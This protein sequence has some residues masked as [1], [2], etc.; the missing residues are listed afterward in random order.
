[1]NYTQAASICIV[2]FLS[3][4]FVPCLWVFPVTGLTL[5]RGRAFV[6]ARAQLSLWRCVIWPFAGRLSSYGSTRESAEG[7]GRKNGD[8]P[9]EGKRIELTLD[10][11]ESS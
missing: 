6:L 9:S 11:H 7:R 10:Y 1:M 2:V 4:S 5:E 8:N 3:A